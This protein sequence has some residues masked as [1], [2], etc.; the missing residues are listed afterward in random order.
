LSSIIACNVAG[1]P[2]SQPLHEDAQVLSPAALRLVLEL[3][4]L[5]AGQVQRQRQETAQQQEQSLQQQNIALEAANMLIN[6]NILLV[7]QLKAVLLATTSSSGGSRCLPPEVLQQAGLQ[8]LQALAASVQQLLLGG[9]GD[10]FYDAA[11][12]NE[13]GVGEQLLALRTTTC[14]LPAAEQ[15]CEAGKLAMSL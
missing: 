1:T 12:R 4:L 3:Q 11:L 15:G 2:G 13:G 10:A 6:S 5:A 9:P 7:R 14:G 8:L